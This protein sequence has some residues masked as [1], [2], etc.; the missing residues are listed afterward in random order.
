LFRCKRR[1]FGNDGFHAAR[2]G[3]QGAAVGSEFGCLIDKLLHARQRLAGFRLLVDEVGAEAV[4][5]VEQAGGQAAM[6]LHDGHEGH[7]GLQC[8]EA[9]QAAFDLAA[10]LALLDQVEE[11]V[12]QGEA[13]N[14]NDEGKHG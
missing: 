4:V 13:G 5:A 2:H 10:L 12:E 7:P 9:V 6:L 14:G 1:E 8:A 11:A 3:F